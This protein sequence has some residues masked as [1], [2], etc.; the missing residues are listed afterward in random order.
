MGLGWGLLGLGRVSSGD[1]KSVQFVAVGGLVLI[2]AGEVKSVRLVPGIGSCETPV[3][4][5]FGVRALESGCF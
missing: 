2:S 5:K 3:P 4:G 1:Y